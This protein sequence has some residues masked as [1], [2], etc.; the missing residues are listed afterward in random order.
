VSTRL[1]ELMD[2]LQGVVPAGIATCAADGTP[3]VTF[4]SY[5]KYLDERHVALSCQFFNKTK[6]NIAQ[7]P[8][9]TLWLMHPVT[10][11]AHRLVIR[12][13]RSEFKGA[14]FEEM[15]LRIE[16]IAA[17][18]GMTG[19]FKLLSADVYEVL[20]IEPVEGHLLADSEAA[21]ALS[22]PPVALRAEGTRGELA[23]LQALSDRISRADCL[24]HLIDTLLDTTTEIFG[25]RHGMVL[26]HDE[27]R[28][29]LYTIDSRGYGRGGSGA[30][31]ALGEGLIGAVAQSRKPLR[32]SHAGTDLRYGRAIRRGVEGSSDAAMLSREIPLP[33]LPDAQSQLVLPLVARGR[34]VGTI[35]LE[36]RDAMKFSEWQES[37]LG[38]A[39]NQAALA[40]ANL[41]E[42]EE[43]EDPRPAGESQRIK[44]LAGRRRTFTF[45][46][47][48]DAVFV[49][50]Q[51]LIRNLPGR[52]LWKIL[53]EHVHRG[54]NEFTNRELRLD[55]TLGL[56]PVKDN[57]ESRLILLRKRLEEKCPDVRMVSTRRGAFVLEAD[58]E[59]RLSEAPG[60]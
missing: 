23:T 10:L 25:V 60:A 59:I 28:A 22:A 18:T 39:A 46:T 41:Q 27:G 36:S 53:R 54:R 24:G 32:V 19:V 40:I 34:L 47:Q 50:G 33:G 58:C 55:A 11:A 6:R 29:R 7:N 38:I 8:V 44:P 21:E 57:L 43:P 48:D 17:H 9:A 14:L 13:L 30:E 56:P 4:L 52:V 42:R 51:Y 5:V 31:V 12:F 26:L 2:C 35:V 15:S 49:D 3:N 45:Y 1:S 16:V 37:F 20:E